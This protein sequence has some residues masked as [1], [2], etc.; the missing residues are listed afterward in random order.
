MYNAVMIKYVEKKSSKMDDST[1]AHKVSCE[2]SKIANMKTNI[3][4]VK[5]AKNENVLTCS[6]PYSNINR[7]ESRNTRFSP[8]GA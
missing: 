6:K 2:L 5:K 4:K 8:A 1:I 3:D 7:A